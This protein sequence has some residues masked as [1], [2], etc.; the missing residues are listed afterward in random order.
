M[1]AGIPHAKRLADL[2]A[3]AFLTPLVL[4]AALLIAMAIL[5][6][7]PGPVVYRAARIGMGGRSF[8]MLKFRTMKVHSA[9]RA[10][11]GTGD[12]RITPIG[13]FLRA[14]RLDELPQLWNVL[15]GQ[16]SFVGPRPEL[17][18]FVARHAE[19]YREIL[20]VA[21]GI[22][23]PTQLR[24]AG[25]EARLLGMQADPESY[26]CEHLLPD[27][28]ALDLAYARDRSLPRDVRFLCQTLVLPVVLTLQQRPG[29][30]RRS[31]AYAGAAMAVVAVPLLFA[32]GLGPPR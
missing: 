23:G 3:L 2:V 19:D 16:M 27:K 13:R 21:P 14:T 15:R 8:A 28:V 12:L 7:S 29:A 1:S 20:A 10:L 25:V 30:A 6:D 31:V 26:Y 18:E 22:T 4:P 17:E 9:G 32:I 11:A 5:L 24:Y